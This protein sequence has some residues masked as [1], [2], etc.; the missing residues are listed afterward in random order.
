M[1]IDWGDGSDKTTI[2]PAVSPV[3]DQ[4]HRYTT[5]G[6]FTVTVTVTDDDGGVS[7]PVFTTATIGPDQDPVADPGGPYG[8]VE[9]GESVPIDGSTSSDPDGEV[10]TYGWSSDHLSS[11]F[12]D[13]TMAVTDYR[14]A[15]RG[16]RHPPPDPGGL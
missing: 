13:P 5:E 15:R 6:V 16:R 1:E 12:G 4:T 7:D 3:R 14:P 11:S 2:D 8:P 10:Q 9:E